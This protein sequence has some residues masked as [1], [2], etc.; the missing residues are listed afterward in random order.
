MDGR[1]QDVF[2]F[3]CLLFV[4]TANGVVLHLFVALGIMIVCQQGQDFDN[5]CMP[6]IFCPLNWSKSILLWS[7]WFFYAKGAKI[8][9]ISVCPW[10]KKHYNSIEIRLDLW[11]YFPKYIAIE[12]FPQSWVKQKYSAC[13]KPINASAQMRQ[14]NLY[15]TFV[16]NYW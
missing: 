8:L 4:A 5:F 12:M 1:G 15:K 7:I 9:T 3:L 10:R 2:E 16:R 13:T 14:S 11:I 6:R